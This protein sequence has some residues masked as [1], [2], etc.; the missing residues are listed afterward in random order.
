MRLT[1]VFLAAI[2]TTASA[3][4]PAKERAV[5]LP[6][7]K[8]ISPAAP[9]RLGSTNSFPATIALSPDGR[10]AALLNEGF[11]AVASQGKQSIS[12]LE[13]TSGTITDFPDD[14]LG[15][16]ARQTF[17][18]GLGFSGDGKHLY[19]SMA[20][21]TD[22]AGKKPGST[23]NGIAVY[24]FADG[25][26]SPERF[27]PIALQPLTPGKRVGFGVR[28]TGDI[29]PYPAGLAVIQRKGREELL[30][31]NNLADNVLLLDATTG[32]VLKQFDLSSS[33]YLPSAFPYTVVAARDS[34]RAWCSLWNGSQVAELDLES[35]RVTRRIK[36]PVRPGASESPLAPGSHPTAM[37]LSPDEKFLYV[38]LANADAVAVVSTSS[39]RTVARLDTR[40]P[41]QQFP[42]SYPNALAQSADGKRLFVADASLNAVAVFDAGQL[43][44]VPA[45]AAIKALGFI[46]SEWYPSALAVHQDQLLIASG[47]GQGTT[48]NAGPDPL[49]PVPGVHRRRKHP[50]IGNLL[51][52]SV[53]SVK[54][55][56]TLKNLDELTAEVEELN[57]FTA[58]PGKIMFRQGT[59]PIKHVIYVLK[60]NRTYDQMFGDLT[61][62]N[63]D[64]SLT[65][66]GEEISPNH[67]RLALQFGVLDNFYDS[68][69]VSGNGHIWSHAAITSDY[70][71]K[72]W[73]ITYRGKSVLMISMG[74]WPMK[75]PWS[76]GSRTSTIR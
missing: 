16:E 41:R 13:L 45:E 70:N 19:A 63:G 8:H 17:F 46:P 39:G 14:R 64:R 57:L 22:P 40:A 52:G 72:T 44:N 60:E 43:K 47:K 55:S 20:S 51:Q 12:V 29:I 30:V 26:V 31:A 36:L 15:E 76:T 73:Q 1:V 25:K 68:G 38:A 49:P 50:Y 61:V 18:L 24:K 5:A 74:R 62:G 11:G 33:R 54:I 67:H 9:G 6:S 58:D 32:Q 59:N 75:S 71:E 42:G 65:M 35:G 37:L 21:L 48:A 34:R 53:A 10:Y 2:V 4:P 27:I 66:Y 7:T 3:Q 69:E 23:G 56:E 28:T